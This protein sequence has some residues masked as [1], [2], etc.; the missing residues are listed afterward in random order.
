MWRH[1]RTLL[2]GYYERG[3]L[4]E[5][6]PDRQPRNEWIELDAASGG[7]RELYDRI[8]EYVS[9]FYR[10]YEA[11]RHGLGFVMTVYRRRLTSSFFAIQRSLERRLAFLRGEAVETGGLTEEDLEEDDLGADVAEQIGEDNRSLFRAEIEYVEDF[12]HRLKMLAT[13]SKLEQLLAD[14]QEIFHSRETVVVFTQ[15]ADTMDHLRDQLRPVY[16]SQ[17]ACYSGRGGEV[18]DGVA[19]VRR[20]KEVVKEAFRTGE[21]VKILVC[22]DAASEGLNLQTCGALIN[23]DMPWNPM[24][25]EQ[26]IGRIDRIGQ[27]YDTVWI[28][29]YF[30]ED[31][32]EADIYRRLADRIGWFEEVVGRLQP[33]LHDVRQAIG[34]LAMT[35]TARRRQLLEDAVA[36][37]RRKLDEQ[38]DVAFDLDAAI[39]AEPQGVSGPPPPVT[40][41][42]LERAL[43]RSQALGGRF[44]PHPEI[45]GAHL[46]SWG[47]RTLDVTFEPRLFDRYPQTLQLLTYGNRLLDELLGTVEPATPGLAEAGLLHL[48]SSDAVG[49][50]TRLYAIPD[51]P[52]ASYAQLSS[53]VE[54]Q[55]PAWI[56]EQ[57][58]SARAFLLRA[59]EEERRRRLGVAE[60]R[61]RGERLALREEAR[62][63]LVRAALVELARSQAPSLFGEAPQYGFGSEVVHDLRRH[64]MP[65]RGLWRIVCEEE[66]EARPTDSYFLEVQGARLDLLERRFEGLRQQ[67]IAVL[68]RW[69]K[70]PPTPSLDESLPSG[71]AEL[72]W[73]R[74]GGEPPAAADEQ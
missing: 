34:S 26:R 13:D 55:A 2:R 58:A 4:A 6:V 24:R 67:G 71:V 52:V 8:D 57:V 49:P 22:T 59:V 40:L 69:S 53:L 29:N 61:W 16:G 68:Q 25:V 28:R 60:E 73:F 23:Y 35:P 70:L 1:T 37:L 11:E 72:T 17:V 32:V 14:L 56:E 64:G 15:Y 27:R 50:A 47:G 19:W 54:H 20:P 9:D 65:F 45:P 10:R 44:A 62:L 33:I 36:D 7:E 3:L 30:Y 43:V 21:Q 48:R 42:D 66:L 74:L 63:V 51:G 18:W 12:L 46:L 39:V 31:T 38:E 41:V 5:R